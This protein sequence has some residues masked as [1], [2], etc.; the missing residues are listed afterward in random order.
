MLE[1]GV[2]LEHVPAHPAALEDGNL[3]RPGYCKCPVRDARRNSNI[4][5]VGVERE[6]GQ[7]L[8]GRGFA[9]APRSADPSQ[10]L[11]VVGAGA[12]SPRH[13]FFQL[14]R[15]EWG[16]GHF[17]RQNEL[18]P[19]RQADGPRHVELLLRILVLNRNQLLLASLELHL[20]AQLVDA[21]RQPGLEH[22]AS[23]L[24]ERLGGLDLRLRSLDPSGVSVGQQIG[25]ANHQH[26]QENRYNLQHSAHRQ[27]LF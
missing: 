21:R 2:C 10:R 3:E 8:G 17:V 5:V 16:V 27:S 6:R 15:L 7:A 9:S 22:V 25:V 23:L 14:D 18:L 4:A 1:N 13:R 20:G 11:L 24:I 19:D 12:V 26:D